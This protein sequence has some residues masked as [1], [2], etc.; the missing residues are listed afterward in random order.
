M[1]LRFENQWNTYCLIQ[2]LELTHDSTRYYLI[3]LDPSM[4]QQTLDSSNNGEKPSGELKSQIKEWSEESI[5]INMLIIFRPI[6][7]S[8]GQHSAF[9]WLDLFSASL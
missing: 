4:F 1:L 2:F 5:H 8:D 9:V 3:P 6:F 7:V